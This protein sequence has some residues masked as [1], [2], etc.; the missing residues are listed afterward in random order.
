MHQ[1]INQLSR[2]EEIKNDLDI[3][4][5]IYDETGIHDLKYNKEL[6]ENKNERLVILEQN[7]I[8]GLECL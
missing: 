2:K 5:N 4:K 6:N 1:V 3:E 7:E 8:I